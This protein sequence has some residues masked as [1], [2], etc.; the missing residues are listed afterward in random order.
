MEGG[1]LTFRLCVTLLSVSVIRPARASGFLSFI[2]SLQF[3]T[4]SDGKEF[5][6]L[7]TATFRT[8]TSK[9]SFL[10][11]PYYFICATLASGRSRL[12]RIMDVTRA[13]FEATLSRAVTT[14]SACFTFCLSLS[15]SFCLSY[16]WNIK[17]AASRAS[18]ICVTSSVKMSESHRVDLPHREKMRRET[19]ERASEGKRNI[20]QRAHS[21]SL[22]LYTRCVRVKSRDIHINARLFG[23]ES[24]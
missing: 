23:W 10:A 4:T 8:L 1:K 21:R 24:F 15:F 16:T 5:L 11:V 7:S 3:L 19:D 2:G 12:F 18:K 14:N 17:F 6:R 22:R 9:R 20:K 13:I